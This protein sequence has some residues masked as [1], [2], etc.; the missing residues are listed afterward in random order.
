MW[1]N[2]MVETTLLCSGTVWPIGWQRLGIA[3]LTESLRW[4]AFGL[5]GAT[6][7]VDHVERIQEAL[8]FVNGRGLETAIE[9]FQL[10]FQADELRETFYTWVSHQRTPYSP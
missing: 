3:L 10:P 8:H 6:T 9:E 2:M 5:L 7:T 4:S 1:C